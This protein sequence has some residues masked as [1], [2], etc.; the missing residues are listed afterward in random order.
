MLLTTEPIDQD[1]KRRYLA[2]CNA[3]TA[4]LEPS[5]S[6]KDY[7][8]AR[9][10]PTYWLLTANPVGK[11]CDK[12]VGGYDYARAKPLLSRLGKLASP[13]PVLAAWD[14]SPE[15]NTS[16]QHQL[17]L[18]LSNFS[19]DD[20]ERAFGIW[21]E[22]LARDPTLWQHGF[23]VVRIRESFRNLIEKYGGQIVEVVNK[24]A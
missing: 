3:F 5:A 11:T 21:I 9:L 7:P 22:Q 4:T 15:T 13:G 14:T 20:M 8:S 17:I 23:D 10:M 12:L 2:A 18:D 6:Y 24:S 19:D 1:T 16:P